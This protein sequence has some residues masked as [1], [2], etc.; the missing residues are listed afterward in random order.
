MSEEK[1]ARIAELEAEL[2]RLRAELGWDGHAVGSVE[3][4]LPSDAVAKQHGRSLQVE[5]LAQLGS[6]TWD[7]RSNDVIWSA[8]MFRILDLDPTRVRPSPT[9]FFASV[10]PD[11]RERVVQTA[12]AGFATGIVEPLEAR[13]VRP[14]GE[15]RDVVLEAIVVH[16]R[17]PERT[18]LVGTLL[19]L[20]EQRRSAR[21]LAEAIDELNEAQRLAK[22]ASW[23]MDGATRQYEWSEHMYE[24]LGVPRAEAPSEAVFYQHFH[25][26]ELARID[27]LR[28]RARERMSSSRS[29][30]AWCEA[31]AKCCM[32]CFARHFSRARPVR[33][34]AC[35]A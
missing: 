28:R 10:H 7:L 23:R 3:S 27:E 32:W 8:G 15:L 29:R 33:S 22:L 19:D 14:N 9:V 16:D 13:I 24:L 30:R 21:L 6:W 4:A 34:S 5:R 20:T 17:A 25:P 26:D 2:G 11:D 35:A 18:Q 1:R 12:Q 31:A